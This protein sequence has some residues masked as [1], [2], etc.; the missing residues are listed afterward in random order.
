MLH[1]GKKTLRRW[2]LAL[3][4]GVALAFLTGTG[5]TG[6]QAALAGQVVRLHVVGESD[7][8]E[9]QAVKLRV[10]DAALVQAEGLLEGV[11]DRDEAKAVLA[12]HLEDLARA[13]AEAAGTAVTASLEED[14]WFPT[15]RYTGFSLPAGRYDALRLTV[16]EGEGRN[17]WCVVFPPLCLGA[18][19]ET[20]AEPVGSLTDEQ[21]RLI[22]GEDEKYELRFR[23]LELWN[24]FTDQWR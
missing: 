5:L 9:D 20:A 2:E 21:V 7:S 18:V 17:W 11:T 14:A 1:S 12:A 19:T 6:E 4:F 24:T 3:L 23:A 22:T 10:R 13:G 8:A 15:K 16:G